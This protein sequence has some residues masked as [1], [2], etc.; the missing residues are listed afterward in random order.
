M[1][2]MVYASCRSLKMVQLVAYSVLASERTVSWNTGTVKAGRSA[3]TSLALESRSRPR[4]G[5]GN[6]SNLCHHLFDAL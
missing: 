2:T 6:I 1:D 5:I 4:H 3:A